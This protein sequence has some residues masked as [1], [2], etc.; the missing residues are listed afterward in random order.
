MWTSECVGLRFEGGQETKEEDRGQRTLYLHP[1]VGVEEDGV[2]LAL[3]IDVRFFE[4]G[5]S[6][7]LI[8]DLK[9]RKMAEWMQNTNV[10]AQRRLF[11]THKPSQPNPGAA[12][13]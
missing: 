10:T 9:M 11:F 6:H 12:A 5:Q 4:E 3:Y 1:N 8:I 7:N 2:G 13:Q